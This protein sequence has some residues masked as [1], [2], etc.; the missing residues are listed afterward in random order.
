MPP[1]VRAPSSTAAFIS[2]AFG[3]RGCVP[4]EAGTYYVVSGMLNAMR[5]LAGR[6]QRA[7]WCM[8]AE[9]AGVGRESWRW[10][11]RVKIIL[12]HPAGGRS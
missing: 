3:S 12:T 5:R 9:V 6:R 8:Q 10:R 7:G 2:Q 1:G 11:A 4:L